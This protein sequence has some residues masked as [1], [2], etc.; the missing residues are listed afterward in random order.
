MGLDPIL[1]PPNIGSITSLL[2]ASTAPKRVCDPRIEL[3]P[4][5]VDKSDCISP[6]ASKIYRSS[7]SCVTF[8]PISRSTWIRMRTSP[9]SGMLEISIGPLIKIVAVRIGS[10]AFFE[11]EI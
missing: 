1:Q 5:I 7:E 8:T 2:R 10:V 11:P 6:E 9:R 3:T 4:L